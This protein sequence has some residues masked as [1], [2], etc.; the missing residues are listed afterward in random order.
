MRS[1][2]IYNISLGGLLVVLSAGC[3]LVAWYAL[4]GAVLISLYVIGLT[5]SRGIV[6]F[7]PFEFDNADKEKNLHGQFQYLQ[8]TQ[9]DS[10]TVTPLYQ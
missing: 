8:I 6:F 2:L 4:H 9:P 10:S 3:G 7:S 5:V 1:R